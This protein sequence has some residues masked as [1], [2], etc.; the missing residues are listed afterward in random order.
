MIRTMISSIPGICFGIVDS[1]AGSVSSSFRHGTCTTRRTGSTS[2]ASGVAEFTGV[3][4]HHGRA[5]RRCRL[6]VPSS[7]RSEV[8]LCGHSYGA[9]G[10]EQPTCTQRHAGPEERRGHPVV[11][12][13]WSKEVHAQGKG[14][15]KL[16][17]Q[18]QRNPSALLTMHEHRHGNQPH[19]ADRHPR[20]KVT[21]ELESDPEPGQRRLPAD[22]PTSGRWGSRG[23]AP[24]PTRRRPGPE[25]RRR[26]LRHQ[27]PCT[28]LEHPPT[29]MAL[30]WGRLRRSRG[31]YDRIMSLIR[32]TPA[33]TG[34]GPRASTTSTPQS[35]VTRTAVQSLHHLRGSMGQAFR[36]RTSTTLPCSF[37]ALRSDLAMSG[38]SGAA[39]F[40]PSL[41]PLADS[42]R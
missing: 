37:G 5:Q 24:R 14:A 38:D 17:S 4:K 25:P 31:K 35:P 7:S 42:V 3:G 15:E 19:Q 2:I 6:S 27:F 21:Q 41:P 34:D 23:R 22:C 18:K 33:P 28:E 10:C 13:T 39:A 12:L 40:H 26:P 16:R 9:N 30:A 8:D 11:D 1:T 20:R 29:T 36:A 32:R